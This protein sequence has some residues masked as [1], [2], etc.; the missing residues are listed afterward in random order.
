MEAAGHAGVSG[1]GGALQAHY[2][3]V[4]P[5]RE[6]EPERKRLTFDENLR[7]KSAV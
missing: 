6:V 2:A 5:L 4:E 3:P 1:A 7:P